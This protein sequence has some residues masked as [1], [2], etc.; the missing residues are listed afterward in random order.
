MRQELQLVYLH[1]C[2]K[3]NDDFLRVLAELLGLPTLAIDGWIKKFSYWVVGVFA[4]AVD[5]LVV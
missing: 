4:T 3:L 5:Y 2:R 1:D